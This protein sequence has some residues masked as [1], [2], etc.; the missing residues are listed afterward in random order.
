MK[1]IVDRRKQLNVVEEQ[2]NLDEF[3]DLFK[4]VKWMKKAVEREL[5]QVDR[6]P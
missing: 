2:K 4:D 3:N 6:K 5:A 1:R